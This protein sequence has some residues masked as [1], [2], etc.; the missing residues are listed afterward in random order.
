MS[1]DTSRVAPVTKFPKNMWSMAWE[2][3]ANKLRYLQNVS[4][5]T[6]RLAKQPVE[7]VN[8]L[9]KV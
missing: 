2:S 6:A 7:L 5:I 9:R 3:L 1:V 8:F 4:K